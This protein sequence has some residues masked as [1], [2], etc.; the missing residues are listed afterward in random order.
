MK[1][2]IFSIDTNDDVKNVIDKVF[3]LSINK[4]ITFHI[5]S[6][7]YKSLR[8]KGHS[9]YNNHLDL[10]T[11][12][13]LMIS[14]GGDGTFL[15]TLGIVRDK[16]IPILGIN[17]GRLGF[18][19]TMNHENISEFYSKII[20]SNYKIEERSTVQVKVLNSKV[21]D[22]IFCVGL[23]EISIVRKNT[24]SLINI[25]TKLDD[26]FLNS[27][28][29]DGLIVSTPTG[30]TGYSLSCGGPIVSPNSNS[31]ILTPISPH[32]LN[33]R[34]IVISDETKIEINVTGRE[35]FHLLSI[36]TNIISLKHGNSIIIEKSPIKFKLV[37]LEGNSYYETLREKLFWGKDKRN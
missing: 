32:N 24:T 27:Y 6:E 36:D 19:S 28:W 7:L 2:A 15:R 4:N 5:Y 31:L 35:D 37:K 13:D 3:K 16:G 8:L 10:K 29:S 20:N 26:Q 33:A 1:I 9:L 25:K 21:L 22:E 18:L 34:P 30:S 23:N 14:I 17:T 12:V 11:E